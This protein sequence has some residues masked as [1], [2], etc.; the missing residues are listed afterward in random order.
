MEGG[1]KRMREGRTTSIKEANQQS[2]K[3]MGNQKHTGVV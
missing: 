3:Q 2:D 1:N